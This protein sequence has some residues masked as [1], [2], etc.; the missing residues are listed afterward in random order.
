MLPIAAHN[1]VSVDHEVGPVR[2]INHPAGT[3]GCRNFND[4]SYQ[5]KTKT[6]PQG[7]GKG[8]TEATKQKGRQETSDKRVASAAVVPRG[9]ELNDGP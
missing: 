6:E 7:K 2:D 5:K 4:A 8:R 1:S 3:I 9:M